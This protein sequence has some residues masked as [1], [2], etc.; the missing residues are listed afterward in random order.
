MT[1]VFRIGGAGLDSDGDERQTDEEVSIR[2]SDGFQRVR[3]A[4][5]C[6]QFSKTVDG[7]QSAEMTEQ[8]KMSFQVGHLPMVIAA[9]RTIQD[10]IAKGNGTK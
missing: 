10:R 7:S 8:C 9:L 2:M 5:R 4:M 1:E 6:I 3:L